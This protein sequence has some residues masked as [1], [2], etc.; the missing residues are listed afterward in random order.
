[1]PEDKSPQEIPDAGPNADLVPLTVDDLLEVSKKFEED[2][3]EIFYDMARGLVRDHEI[4][5]C[6]LLLATWNR[7]RFGL[8]GDSDV[9]KLKDALRELEND[10]AALAEYTIQ[11][12]DLAEHRPRIE[13][14]FNKLKPITGVE[15]TGA[16]K[17][18]H[19]KNPELFVMWDDYI[20]GGKDEEF[21]KNLP[22]VSSRQWSFHPYEK[23]GNG[24]VSFLSHIQNRVRGLAWHG[25]KTLAKAIDEFNYVKVTVPIRAREDEI[26]AEKKKEEAEIRAEVKRIRKERKKAAKVAA[27]RK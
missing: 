9:R 5:A 24:Y 19:L 23:S 15:N 16:T 22:C 27:D 8:A 4:E 11:T 26:E 21:Y 2:G 25:P 7:M 14:M 6:V 17:V 13:R 3:G 18:M 12:I 10:F 1:M 20:R